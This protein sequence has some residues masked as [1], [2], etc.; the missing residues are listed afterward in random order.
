MLFPLQAYCCV[1]YTS[2]PLQMLTRIFSPNR[3]CCS[4]R[5]EKK[6]KKMSLPG[7]LYD[8]K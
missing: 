7:L 1:V 3:E 8:M 2:V 4:K 6:K 5:W